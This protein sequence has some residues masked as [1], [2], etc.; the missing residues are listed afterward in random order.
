MHG[1]ILGRSVR[2][3]PELSGGGPN[4]ESESGRYL[5]TV[6]VAGDIGDYAAYTGLVLENS[7][8]ALRLIARFG[9]KVSFAE[10][11]VHFPSIEREKY[12][13]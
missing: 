3:Y 1:K 5:I 7:P 8:A 13:D 12:S 11:K 10:A 9:D 4:L 2:W 6:L